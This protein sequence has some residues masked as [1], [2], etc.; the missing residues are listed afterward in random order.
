MIFSDLMD[1][2]DYSLKSR[3]HPRK[4]FLWKYSILFFAFGKSSS[5]IVGDQLPSATISTLKRWIK[6]HLVPVGE[7]GCN[8]HPQSQDYNLVIT[9]L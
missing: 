9:R 4:M 8:H 3:P 5:P 6:V 7:S 2:S 1:I